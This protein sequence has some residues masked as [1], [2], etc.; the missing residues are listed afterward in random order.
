MMEMIE[1]MVPMAG[2]CCDVFSGA[3]S[4]DDLRTGFVP[5]VSYDFWGPYVALEWNELL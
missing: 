2:G 4:S 1:R 5:D 3:L